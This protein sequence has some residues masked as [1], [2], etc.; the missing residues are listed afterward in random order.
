MKNRILKFILFP[1]IILI[2]LL[3]YLSVI[4]I[5]TETFNNQIKEQVTKIDKNLNLELKKIKLTLDLLNFK[6][7][8]KTVG[9]TVYYSNRPLKLEYIKSQISLTSFV[10]KKIISSDIEIVSRSILFKDFIKFLRGVK[11][12]PQLLILE[13]AVKKGYIIFDLNLNLNEKGE[14]NNN[15]EL[16]GSLKNAKINFFNDNIFE[17]INF[18][19]N[20]NNDNYLFKDIKFKTNKV[21]FT[22]ELLNIKK[23]ENHFVVQGEFQNRQT[24]LN[25][26][27]L[28]LFK[29][30]LNDLDLEDTNFNSNN[31]FSFNIDNELN[32]N[33]IVIESKLNIDQFKYKQSN[34]INKYFSDLNET[35]VLKDQQIKLKYVNGEILIDGQGKIKLEEKFDQIQY[36]VSKNEDDFKIITDLKLENI[37]LKINRYLKNFF[38]KANNQINLKDQILNI[39]Y[40]NKNFLVSGKGKIKIDS[41]IEDTQYIIK[42]IKEKIDFDL[43]LNLTK[44]KFKIGPLNYKK[45]NTSKASLSIIGSYDS[46]ENININN[47]NILEDKNNINISNLV[48]EKNNLISE[49]EKANFDFVDKDN[50]QNKLKI[51]KIDQYNYELEGLYY[52]AKNLIEELLDGED[53]VEKK[54]FK[55]NIGLNVNINEVL[56]DENYFV[57]KLKGNLF[58]KNN[59]VDSAYFSANFRNK[60]NIYLTITTDNEGNKITTLNSSWAKPL[61]NRYKFIKGFDEGNLDFTSYKINQVSSSKLVI[62]NFKVK[63]IPVLAKLLA[64]ASLQGIA[65]LLTGE[66]LR[67]TDLEM[68]FSNEKNLMR[69]EELYAIGPSISILLEGY[70]EKDKLISLRGTLVPATT[71]NRTIASIPLLG[72]LLVGKKAGEGVFGVSFK[73]KGPPNDLETT[74][75]PI[76]TLTPRFITRT[77]EKIKKN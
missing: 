21:K 60:D 56:I 39:K 22:S 4:G 19:F 58:I 16:N 51:R 7:N 5:E 11:D 70:I 59:K 25:K 72:D 23:K 14:V 76:K 49:F 42:K 18:N 38:P 55:N 67:F 61:V 20:L 29:V 43:K 77:L 63:E 69:I 35:I 10:K 53:K 1:F 34:F 15:Y 75:N 44:T 50:K 40:Q 66:G 37:N 68:N 31:I 8:T 6:I 24:S 26:S 46:S 32:F 3:M 45:R 28:R 64:L 33:N 17:A 9:S 74:V 73:I 36:L 57:K 41:E 12:T 13:N 48:I 54:M 30:N 52:N 27:L 62:D 65:D 71:I 47:L 2:S